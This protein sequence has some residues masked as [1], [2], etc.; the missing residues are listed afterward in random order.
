MSLLDLLKRFGNV[1][2]KEAL[3]FQNALDKVLPADSKSK[4]SHELEQLY[5]TPPRI[6]II[7]KSGVGKSS[8]INALFN[9]K[10]PVRVGHVVATTKKVREITVSLD[11]ERGSIIIIDCP[12]LGESIKADEQFIP[13]YQQLLPT[14]DVA[15]WIVKADERALA[16]DQRHIRDVLTRELRERLV[17]GINQV[18]LVQP[19]RW[20]EEFNVPSEEQEKSINRKIR[21]V[22]AKLQYVGVKPNFIVPYSAARGY[23]LTQLFGAMLNACP[24]ERAWILDGRKKISPYSAPAV[25]KDN[26]A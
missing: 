10:P 8:T 5:N 17:V 7:G 6:A 23:R 14:C 19:G 4:M 22:K 21:D 2:E 11:A 26:L 12:G 3:E 1:S 13:L 25:I 24:D 15:L 20:I 18:D 16:D 9:P